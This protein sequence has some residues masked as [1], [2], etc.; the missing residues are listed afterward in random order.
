MKTF[1]RAL[2]TPSLASILQT[3]V[4]TMS[5]SFALQAT[6]LASPH[7]PTSFN[8]HPNL[9]QRA[10]TEAFAWIA[11]HNMT[12]SEYQATF[13]DLVGVQ[14]YNLMQVSA[15]AVGNQA[16]F[17]AIWNNA[18]SDYWQARHD[19]TSQG[20]Q[21]NFNTLVAQGYRLSDVC[22]Y[23]S[24]GQERY[25]AIWRQSAGPAWQARHGQTS[26]QYQATFDDLVAQGY[27]PMVVSGYEVGGTTKYASLF[28]QRANSP[29][30]VA[31]HGLTSA[32]Y[33]AAF[34]TYT[35]QGY[36]P[37]HVNGY[38]V[39]GQA[40]YAA[41]WEKSPSA[42]W[43]A[44]HGMTSADYQRAFNEYTAQGYALKKVSGYGVGGTAY[45]AAIWEK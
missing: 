37:I 4:G 11:R 13:N 19:Q 30:W 32:A 26:G 10:A 31:R 40:R 12:S 22:G 15:Y 16:R 44:R 41:I 25:A 36:K 8:A 39:G 42:G 7:A 34:D 3:I 45:F 43:V 35:Q 20:Y 2:A 24:G 6:A 14:G 29:A 23:T 21:A 17:A 9:A 18:P 1:L 38:T 27:R 5:V 33:Q 28:E